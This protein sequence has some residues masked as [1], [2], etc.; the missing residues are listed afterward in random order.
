MNETPPKKRETIDRM[1]A[2]KPLSEAGVP[3]HVCRQ[4]ALGAHGAHGNQSFGARALFDDQRRWLPVLTKSRASLAAE[5]LSWPQ[6]E[7]GCRFSTHG[8]ELIY[9]PQQ[10]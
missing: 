5:G 7:S 6:V 3:G 4:C 8:A 10:D 9:V 2:P 1:V